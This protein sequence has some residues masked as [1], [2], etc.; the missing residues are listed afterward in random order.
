MRIAYFA[1]A[2]SIHTFKWVS[3][4]AKTNQVIL[5]CE[6]GQKINDLFDAYPEIIIFPI[7]PKTY[8]LRKFWIRKR[9]IS[10][11]KTIVNK[12]NVEIIHC[13][14]AIPYAFW[15][16]HIGFKNYIITTRGSDILID[17]HKTFHSPN[18]LKERIVYY[19]LKHLL[20]NSLKRAKYI[21]STSQK[22]QDILKK[23]INDDKKLLVV[24]TGVDTINFLTKYESVS[25]QTEEFVVLSNR[26]LWPIY[27][28]HVIADAFRILKEKSLLIKIKLIILK[29]NTDTEYLKKIISQIKSN[30]LTNEI[31]L[32]EVKTENELI[33]IYKNSDIVVMIPSSDGT[34]VSAIEAMLAKKPVILGPLDYDSDLFN[35]DTVWKLTSFDSEELADTILQI[36]YDFKKDRMNKIQT[37][38][39][40]AVRIVDIRKSLSQLAQLYSNLYH[41]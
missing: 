35:E 4:F 33:Q 27:N 24:R 17:Y 23:F 38:Y 40:N 30:K 19:F 18:N 29:Y 1:N 15:P 36:I 31:V 16:Y 11:I 2:S 6:E 10:Q 7:L 26:V 32:L 37:A 39:E 28:T 41:S 12:N 22:Q 8:P 21:T 5:F 14:Y 13:L 25:R 34:P 20:E 9:T 3:H